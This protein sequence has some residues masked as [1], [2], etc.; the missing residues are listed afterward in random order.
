MLSP[1]RILLQAA[2]ARPVYRRAAAAAASSSTA[3]PPTSARTATSSPAAASASRSTPA[4]A[5]RAGLSAPLTGAFDP[6]GAE[7]ELSR[8]APL[9]PPLPS[10]SS[11]AS[12]SSAPA[13]TPPRAA[14]AGLGVDCSPLAE[15]GKPPFPPSYADQLAQSNT[16]DD[17]ASSGG[18]DWTT[19]WNGL[20]TAVIS[21]E[22]AQMLMR[23]LMAEEIQIKPDGLLY[24][25]E[26]L[27]RR[28]LN[29]TLGPGQWGLVPRG[30][31]TIQKGILT[32][33]WGL[34]VGGRLVSVARGEQQY[35]DPSG[36]PTAAEACKSNAL[37]RCCKDLGIAGEL[38][39]PTFIRAFKKTQCVEA[40]VEHVGTGKKQKRW[41][42]KGGQFEYPL[43]EV[44]N[45]A[46]LICL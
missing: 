46:A 6:Y 33:E 3:T 35:F 29:T 42:K 43:K 13:P 38:W 24:L 27:Y 26:I 21:R 10:R 14:A 45:Y 16:T 17:G 32:R 28:I 12:S 4:P 39:D 40:W 15:F 8:V 31:E 30:P 41:K 19:A 44:A 20:G 25:P 23:P 7:E 37:M 34:V 11:A 2:S 5:P 1:T 18:I 9:A 36:L 22:Q